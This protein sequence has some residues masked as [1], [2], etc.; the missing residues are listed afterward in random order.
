MFMTAPICPCARRLIQMKNPRM[1]TTG[2]N[3]VRIEAM[4]FEPLLL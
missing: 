2:S 3:S 4:M 1:R